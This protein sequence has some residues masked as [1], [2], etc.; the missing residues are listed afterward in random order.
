M[1]KI[2]NLIVNELRRAG[3]KSVAEFLSSDRK[4][5]FF[6]Q[7][8]QAI[9]CYDM[10]NRLGISVEA[11]LSSNVSERFPTLPKDIPSYCVNDFGKIKKEEYDVLLALNEKYNREVIVLLKENGFRYVY[12]SDNW[13]ETNR[14]YRES[15][16][17]AY[18]SEKMG[19]DYNRTNEI[20][21]Y[22]GF[23]I[24]NGCNQSETYSSMLYGE[25]YDIIAPSLWEDTR[26]ELEGAYENEVVKVEKND[27]VLD[28]GANIGMFSC[29]AA[30]K[31][32]HVYAFE[33]VPQII[34]YLEENACLYDNITIAEYAVSNSNG[35]CEF[36][37]STDDIDSGI[38]TMIQ[39]PY[40]VGG[41]NA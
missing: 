20:I 13:I 30:A 11:L 8:K 12:Y 26:F 27:V 25:F 15:F 5:I 32:K 40:F 18:L 34:S 7:G 10:C 3:S 21:S 35:E 23:K 37:I 41:G 2:K 28:L 9:I 6:G 19:S 4:K 24:Y 17:N 1:E 29:V 39:K 36:Y 16:F 38:N 14:T 33:P 22:N 31:G